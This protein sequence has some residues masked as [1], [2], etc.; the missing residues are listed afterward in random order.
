ASAQAPEIRPVAHIASVASGSI[1]GVVLDEHGVPVAGALVSAL[2][3]T[4]SLAGG[5]RGGRVEL[6]PLSP[7]P[8]LVRARL[9]GLGAPRG[10]VVDVRPS[11]RS[12]SSIA[13]RHVSAPSTATTPPVLAA[14]I[15]SIPETPSQPDNGSSPSPATNTNDDDHG[16]L[17]WRLR[18]IRRG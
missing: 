5:D 6:H 13:L 16:E 17:A 12:S 10:Q 14:G 9:T 15:G 7:G 1:Q 8:H 2:G 4:T 3:A 18:H 11:S